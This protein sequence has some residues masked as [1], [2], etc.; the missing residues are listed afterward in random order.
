M[1]PVLM[2]RRAGLLHDLGTVSVPT[3]MW[4]KPGPLSAAKWER[5][6]LH[7]YYTERV[8]A[9]SPLLAPLGALA[10]AHHERLDGSGYH[11]NTPGA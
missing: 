2:L 4:E 6:R 7:P 10:G 5:V 8:L 11:R 3:S 9:R 1:P